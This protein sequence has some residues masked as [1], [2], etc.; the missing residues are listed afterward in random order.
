MNAVALG[1]LGK[2]LRRAFDRD[3]RLDRINA[4]YAEH[5]F[6]N[7]E[8]Q[9]GAPFDVLGCAGKRETKF[10]ELFD[11]HGFIVSPRTRH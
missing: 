2:F 3:A 4:G 6:A 5:L 7:I 11:L 1:Q 9:V 8:T 10:A